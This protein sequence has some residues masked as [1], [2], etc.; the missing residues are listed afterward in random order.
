MPREFETTNELTVDATP[1]QVWDAIATGPGVDAWFMGRTEIEPG[2][3]VRTEFPGGFALRSAIT[4]W[5]P[6]HRLAY[7]G[8]PGDDGEFHAFEFLVEG[9]AGS[10]TA[11]RVVHSGALANW[12]DE[13]EAMRE[14]DA[15]YFRK[16]AT[17]VSHFAGRTA[18]SVQLERAVDGGHDEVMARLRGRLG[19]ADGV[20][21][22]D[23]VRATPDGVE[24]LDGVVDY[25]TPYAL[26][27][28]TDE[29]MVRFLHGMGSLVVGEHRY[30]GGAPRD[31]QGWLERAAA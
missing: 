4:E 3:S 23:R 6:P 18:A 22:G 10:A 1:E 8:Q 5:D 24:P 13:Y 20:A 31:W 15:M 9:R 19:L 12:D 11:V 2:K 27:L 17:Y 14:G 30:D 16:L 28:R 29:S 21:E 25:V 26:G 7:R